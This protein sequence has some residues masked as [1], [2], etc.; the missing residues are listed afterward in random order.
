MNYTFSIFLIASYGLFQTLVHV[1]NIFE[2]K[3][4]YGPFHSILAH[5]CLQQHQKLGLSYHLIVFFL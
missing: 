5:K 1:I 2:W 3:Y 4:V